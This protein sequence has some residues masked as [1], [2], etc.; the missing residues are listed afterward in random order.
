MADVVQ[1]GEMR[2][3]AARC[4][5]RYLSADEQGHSALASILAMELFFD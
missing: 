5:R 3:L 2:R 1:E 4:A